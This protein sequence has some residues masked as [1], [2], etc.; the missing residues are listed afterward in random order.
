MRPRVP[1]VSACRSSST[2]AARPTGAAPEDIAIGDRGATYPDE[3]IP[4]QV[5]SANA[6]R[7]AQ[8]FEVQPANC[9]TGRPRI[10]IELPPI[11]AGQIV[12]ITGP[13]GAGKSSLLQQVRADH[14]QRTFADVAAVRWHDGLVIDQFGDDIA[15]AL[16]LLARFGLGEAHTYLRPPA[17]LSDGQQWRLRLARA[18]HDSPASATLVADEFAALLD[19]VTA[20]VVARALRRAIDASPQRSAIVATSHDDL[21]GALLPDVVVRCDFGRATVERREWQARSVPR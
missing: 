9:A 19:R 1:A 21:E 15:G 11:T 7:V 10:A 17:L 4:V 14:P 12:L 8:W 18:L 20:H 2:R 3:G 6:Q 16:M 5:L 13:S